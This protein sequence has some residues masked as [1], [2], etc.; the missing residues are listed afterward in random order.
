V[1][2]WKILGDTGPYTGPPVPF[3]CECGQEAEVPTTGDPG[4]PIIASFGMHLVFDPGDYVPPDGWL[5]KT[6][7]CR[8]CRRIYSE[9]EGA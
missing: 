4:A 3:Q 8:S 5:P 1:R 9:S 2:T 6:I 7:Q